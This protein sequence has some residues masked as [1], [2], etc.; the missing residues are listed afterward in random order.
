MKFDFEMIK[1]NIKFCPR[2]KTNFKK[3]KEN[4]L[5]CG[6][7]SFNFYIDPQPTNAVILIN[8]KGEILLVK[9]KTDP[10][11]GWW[12]LPGGFVD[13]NE[14]IEQSMH[15]EIKEELGIEVKNLEYFTST[16]DIYFF[17]DFYRPTIAAIFIAKVDNQKIEP[18]D[19]AEEAIF[20]APK[21][22]PFEKIAFPS[23]AEV[24]KEFISA[25]Y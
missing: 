21:K 24:L 8:K 13:P 10:K 15:R 1:E 9:R 17:N 20:F 16:S 6:S 25:K 12:D 7:C 22:I 3:I 23:L 19:D 5:V 18:S 11:R 2:C 4:L 14:T